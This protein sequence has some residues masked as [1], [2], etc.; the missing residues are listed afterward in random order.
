MS[1]PKSSNMERFPSSRLRKDSMS[2]PGKM[3]KKSVQQGRSEHRGE[4]YASVR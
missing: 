1:L 2:T 4:T 3:L